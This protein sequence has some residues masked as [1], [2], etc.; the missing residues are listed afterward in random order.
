MRKE[1]ET[2]LELVLYNLQTV[3]HSRPPEMLIYY[4]KKVQFKHRNTRTMISMPNILNIAFLLVAIFGLIL[5]DISSV[6]SDS[7]S[8]SSLPPLLP[9][10][11]KES[12]EPEK[13]CDRSR[14]VLQESHGLISSGPEF[15]NYTQNTNCE[16]LIKPLESSN[17]SSKMS[18]KNVKGKIKYS[19]VIKRLYSITLEHI[20]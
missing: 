7:V 15:S 9:R 1:E 16:W 3:Y 8:A 14:M 17:N 2:H 6:S 4:P 12:K 19:K 13:S 11:L 10:G 20:H 5:Y 18:A